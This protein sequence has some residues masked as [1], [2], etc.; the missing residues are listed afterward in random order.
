MKNVQVY[1]LP[2]GFSLSHLSFFD[3]ILRL[4]RKKRG[5]RDQLKNIFR[6]FSPKCESLNFEAIKL[7]EI[8]FFHTLAVTRSGCRGATRRSSLP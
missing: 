7:G 6:K 2:A 8:Q 5:Y 1:R 4:A 3:W